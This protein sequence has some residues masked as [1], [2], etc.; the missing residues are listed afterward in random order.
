[1]PVN[2]V[3]S[4]DDSLPN[5]LFKVANVIP[6]F[7]SK[8]GGP[9]P[10]VSGIAAAGTGHWQVELFTT[11]YQ[12]SEADSLRVGEFPGQVNLLPPALHTPWGGIRM[13]AGLS[14]TYERL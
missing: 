4:A 6:T 5:R 1:M 10:A 11:S 7:N 8:S 9:P 14:N 3:P 13:M 12:E 2:A